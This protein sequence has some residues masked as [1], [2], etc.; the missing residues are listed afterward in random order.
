MVTPCQEFCLRSVWKDFPKYELSEISLNGTA[1]DFSVDHSAIEKGVIFDIQEY[2]VTKNNNNGF[3]I[4]TFIG[5]LCFHGSLATKCT[6]LNDKPHITRP[7]LI[8]LNWNK[9]HHYPFMVSL[10]VTEVLILLLIHLWIWSVNLKIENV[11]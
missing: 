9:L 11:I 6:S 7:A 2:S 8:D 4:K 3:I 10:D 5:I 1:H